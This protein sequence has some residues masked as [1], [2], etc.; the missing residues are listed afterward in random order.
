[1]VKN[2]GEQS[3]EKCVGEKERAVWRGERESEVDWWIFEV[4][5][6]ISIPSP[7]ILLVYRKL[8]TTLVLYPFE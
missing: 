5:L 6:G 7:A 1:M 3:G 8:T 4:N 2:G